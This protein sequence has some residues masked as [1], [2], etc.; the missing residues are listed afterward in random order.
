MVEK[1]HNSRVLHGPGPSVAEIGIRSPPAPTRQVGEIATLSFSDGIGLIELGWSLQRQVLDTCCIYRLNT[2][3]SIYII[4]SYYSQT[5]FILKSQLI[6]HPDFNSLCHLYEREMRG[7]NA[8]EKP[9][10]QPSH[11]F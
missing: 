6:Y 10:S 9:I 1:D 8:F 11:W 2:H 7:D 5:I 3:R 4:Y